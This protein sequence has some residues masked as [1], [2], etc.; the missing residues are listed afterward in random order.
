VLAAVERTSLDKLAATR[1][2][3]TLAFQMQRLAE[4]PLAA[5]VVELR[6]SALHKLEHVN[7]NW[8][9]DQLA[10]RGFKTRFRF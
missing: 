9:A 6:C 10:L 2:D 8:L 7:D 4:L 3:G 5:V 1:S